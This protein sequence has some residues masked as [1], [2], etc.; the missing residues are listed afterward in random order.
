MNRK[1]ILLML[2]FLNIFC[3]KQTPEFVVKKD[4]V[5]LMKMKK[6]T[7]VTVTKEF[8]MGKGKK[9]VIVETKPAISVS[10]YTISGVGFRN[11]EDT[12]KYPLK[13][14]MSTVFKADLDKNGYNEIYII[15]KA[16]G[17]G[18]FLDI[19]GVTSME[20]NTFSEIIIN[21]ITEEDTK[22]DNMFSGYMGNDTIYLTDERIIREF[23][24]YKSSDYNNLP[25]GG[26]R[27]IIYLLTPSDKKYELVIAGV[28][29]IK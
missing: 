2:L 15:T 8:T 12:I 1:L 5:E 25:K 11:S 23:P 20:D 19:L 14:P 28:E 6:D 13:D 17:P 16:S 18:Y 24:V 7:A 9:F 4:S 3:G 27:K 10:N 21:K 26:R 22:R 29:N